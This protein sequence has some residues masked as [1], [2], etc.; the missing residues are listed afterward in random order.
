MESLGKRT[1]IID[2]SI[3]K[4]TQEMEECKR[5]VRINKYIINENILYFIWKVRDI[6]HP[7]NL[8]HYEKIKLKN[9]VNRRRRFPAQRTSTKL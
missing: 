7:G 9:N 8:G 3:T 6:S 1:G 4:R 5:H 2:I